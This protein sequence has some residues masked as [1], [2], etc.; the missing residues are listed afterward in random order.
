MVERRPEKPAPETEVGA[1]G[2]VDWGAGMISMR[3]SSERGAYEV[4]RGSV[5]RQ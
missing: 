1:E 2:M 5:E 3:S 4:L